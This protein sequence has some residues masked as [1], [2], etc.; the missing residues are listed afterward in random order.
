LKQF[1]NTLIHA[2]RHTVNNLKTA[3]KENGFRLYRDSPTEVW[4][5]LG[6]YDFKNR[7]TNWHTLV[8]G[9]HPENVERVFGRG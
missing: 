8:S 9:P 1:H 5:S 7:D 2:E 6:N 4:K 3:K